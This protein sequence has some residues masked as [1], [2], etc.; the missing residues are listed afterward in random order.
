MKNLSVTKK[1]QLGITALVILSS[2][3]SLVNYMAYQKVAR[4]YTEFTQ[5]NDASRELNYFTNLLTN[6]TL[7]FMD[8]IVDKDSGTVDKTITDKNDEFTKWIKDNNV[9]FLAH[10]KFIDPAFNNSAFTKKIEQYSSSGSNMITDIKNKKV[11]EL[12]KY[13]DVIDGLNE[14]LQVDVASKLNL[15]NERFKAAAVE[16][17]DAQQMISKSSIISLISVL[18]CGILIAMYVIRSIKATLDT[19]GKKLTEGTDTVLKSSMEFADLGVMIKDS[20]NKQASSLQESVSAIEEI[21]ATVDRNADLSNESVSIAEICVQSSQRGKSAIRD[22]VSAVG[23]IE[24]DQAKTTKMLEETAQEIRE[25]VNV[26]KGIG[27]KTDVINDIVFQTKLLSFNA[28][29]EAARAGE[30]G[31]GFAV[32]AEEIGN[33]ATMSGNAAKEINELLSS[34]IQQV[35]SIV[36]KTERSSVE[37]TRSSKA[38]IETGVQTARNCDE[39]L[40]EIYDHVAKMKDM[41]KEINAGSS[42]QAQGISSISLAMNQLDHITNENV[43]SAEKCATSAHELSTH[44]RNLEESAESLFVAIKG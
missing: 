29:V 27:Q 28:S 30:H 12:D 10:I 25:M 13:D 3:S 41:I 43:V 22:M 26:I 2:V 34:S 32:V 11:D 35:G 23:E 6:N 31:K 9:S 18:L 4:A 16:V 36:E 5:L 19:A 40:V 14:S 37:I 1:L 42:E 17:E 21:K 8:A 39:A 33:L 38:S 15:A 20:T 24:T 7:G 44:S